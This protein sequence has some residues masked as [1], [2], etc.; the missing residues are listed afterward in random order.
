MLVSQK[1]FCPDS[2]FYNTDQVYCLNLLDLI[3]SYVKFLQRPSGFVSGLKVSLRLNRFAGL[4]QVIK[5]L[6]SS[7]FKGLFVV[8]NFNMLNCC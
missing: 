5:T 6:R 4:Q 8:N 3:L 7:S 1:L 2:L